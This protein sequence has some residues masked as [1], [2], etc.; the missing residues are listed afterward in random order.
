MAKAAASILSPVFGIPSG[1]RD[2]KKA[3]KYAKQQGRQQQEYLRQNQAANQEQSAYNKKMYEGQQ[4]AIRAEQD[5]TDKQLAGLKAKNAEGMARSNRR[6]IRGGI[7]G[8]AQTDVQG[9]GVSN[10]RLG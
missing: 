9:G 1:Y 2:K 7:F 6:R 10:P 8:D 5:R 4:S 3:D